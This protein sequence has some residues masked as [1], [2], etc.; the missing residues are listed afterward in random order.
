M[1]N[2]PYVSAFHHGVVAAAVIRAETKLGLPH[3]SPLFAEI[4]EGI[5]DWMKAELHDKFERAAHG[6]GLQGWV[7]KMRDARHEAAKTN[8]K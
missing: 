1:S 5:D 7:D 8:G 2:Q 3:H 4:M 6:D